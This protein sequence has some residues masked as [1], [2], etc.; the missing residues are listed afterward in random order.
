MYQHQAEPTAVSSHGVDAANFTPAWALP[1]LFLLE[2]MIRIAA[3]LAAGLM[4]APII[5]AALY[6]GS[7]V[8]T[9]LSD[10]QM[11][12]MVNLLLLGS[13][14]AVLAKAWWE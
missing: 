13:A 1:V 10:A 11:L 4:A 12:R 6:A 9:R 14:A 2:G 5:V 8:H 7:H 3:L